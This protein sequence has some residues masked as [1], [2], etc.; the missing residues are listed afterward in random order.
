MKN[1]TRI[2]VLI[3]A[4]SYTQSALAQDPTDDYKKHFK[5]ATGLSAGLP[6][7]DPYDLNLGADVRLLYSISKSYSLSFTVGYNTLLVKDENLLVKDDA[8][9]FAY[10]PVKVGYK[11]FLFQNEFYVMGEIGGA[12]SA[13][14]DYDKNSMIFSPSVGYASKYA[15]ISLRY[16]FIKDFPIIKNNEIDNG[17]AQLMLRVAYTFDL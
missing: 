6:L 11:T 4:F 15:D 1:I 16:E 5:L 9:N 8:V 7:N 14:K 3:C 12:F 10:V 2:I 17:Y 13:T